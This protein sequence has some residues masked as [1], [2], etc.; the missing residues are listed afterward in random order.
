MRMLL[1]AGHGQGDPGACAN[2]YKEAEL[3]RGLV[4]S[5][6]PILRQYAEVDVFDTEKNMYKFLQ[7]NPF[8]FTKYDYVFEVHFDSCVNDTLGDGKTTGTGI[9]VHPSEKAVTVEELILKNIARFGFKNRGVKTR[10]DLQNM[11]ICKGKQG[12]SYALL[13]TCFIDD[14]DDIKLYVSLKENIAKAIADGIINGFGLKKSD[15][16][17]DIAECYGRQHINELA[18]MGIVNGKGDGKF[19]PKENVT[20]EEVAIM[21]R[22]AIRYI[23]G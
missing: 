8:D 11:N 14:V 16:F 10:S 3:V 2:N 9:L 1:I 17:D 22:N 23:K 12:V 5:L 20:R 13:E 21:I 4:S 18:E 19:Y 6:S 7:T 15:K